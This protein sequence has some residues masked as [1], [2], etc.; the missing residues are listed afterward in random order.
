MWPVQH[1]RQCFYQLPEMA[2]TD[3]W[4]I[5]FILHYNDCVIW[6]F[7]SYH[8]DHMGLTSLALDRI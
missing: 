6:G 2:V 4:N 5:F 8:R 7:S 3:Y 1:L